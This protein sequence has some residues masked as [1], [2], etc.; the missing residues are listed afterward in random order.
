MTAERNSIYGAEAC[1][2]CSLCLLVCPV[3]RSTFDIRLT[4]HG[5]AKALQHG[6]TAFDVA[7]SIDTCTLCGAC[8]P[9][10]P[11]EIALVD[12][13]LALRRDLASTMPDRVGN[14]VVQLQ[15]GV[16]SNSTTA[17]SAYPTVLLADSALSEQPQLLQTVLALFSHEQAGLA[18][19]SGADIA[20]A[21]EAGA[22]VP[23][24][25]LN[26]F[27]APLRTVRRMI[28]CDGVLLRALRDWLPR[29]R[30]D[31]LGEAASSLAGVRARLRPDD[32]YVIESR[33]YHA[34]RERLVA[35]YDQ[36]RVSSGCMM[37]LDLQRL[38]IPTT[39]SHQWMPEK[40]RVDPADQ[41]RWI[42]EGRVVAR[43]VVEDCR[44]IAVFQRVAPYPV[45]HVAQLGDAR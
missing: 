26:R 37:N 21:L 34:D 38:A 45:L 13:V 20:L 8:E 16:D 42:L 23:E 12:M 3:W 39:A 18:A 40:R 5:R 6:A 22:S 31:S 28:V 10:C 25:R 29:T 4:P 24:E 44:D 32:F 19:D 9:V 7:D 35:H 41:A 30:I 1:S 33:A 36:L 2:G 27:L 11:E 15:Q 14:A 17:L 43:V